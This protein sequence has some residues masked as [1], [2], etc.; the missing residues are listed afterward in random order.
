ME[1]RILFI[2]CA[3][4]KLIPQ[5]NKFL[6]VTY[7]NKFFANLRMMGSIYPF[8]I[9][10]KIYLVNEMARFTR[11]LETFKD[12]AV[13]LINAQEL[14]KIIVVSEPDCL[15]YRQ[16]LKFNM[17]D[18]FGSQEKAFIEA[19]RRFKIVIYNLARI[20]SSQIFAWYIDE[21]DNPNNIDFREIQI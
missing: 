5:I 3:G 1:E 10:D 16:L 9:K 14:N 4:S 6:E 20:S 2:D 21:Y 11:D 7:S 19:L 18:D 15:R 17:I 13:Q 8:L 12:Q